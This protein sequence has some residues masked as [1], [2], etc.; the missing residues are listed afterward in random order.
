MDAIIGTSLL[1]LSGMAVVSSAVNADLNCWFN[2]LTL[3][4]NITLYESFCV[5]KRCNSSGFLALALNIC[6]ER[7]GVFIV[8]TA[9]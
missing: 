7:L 8:I 4:K 2:M 6:P 3:A 9:D 5:L 1:P